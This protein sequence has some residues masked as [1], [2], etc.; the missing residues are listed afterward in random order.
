MRRNRGAAGVGWMSAGPGGRCGA[1]PAS[2]R[3][4]AGLSAADPGRL[5]TPR[6]AP[7]PSPLP[8][9]PLC[10]ASPA[11][12]RGILGGYSHYACCRRARL[13]PLVNHSPRAWKSARG[14]PVGAIHASDECSAGSARPTFT[15]TGLRWP[16]TH[17]CPLGS[18]TP[19]AAL[20]WPPTSGRAGRWQPGEYDAGHEYLR[21]PNRAAPSEPGCAQSSSHRTGPSRPSRAAARPPTPQPARSPDRARSSSPG[22]GVRRA[23]PERARARGRAPGSSAPSDRPPSLA[24]PLRRSR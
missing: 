8:H 23:V 14:G 21:R 20:G 1:S 9:R 10:G 18:A 15:G 3:R 24:S 7:A 12:L 6:A 11:S 16:A 22:R 5:F 17:R 19:S 2:L 4:R 13:A